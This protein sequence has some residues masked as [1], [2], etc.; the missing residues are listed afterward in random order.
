ML[1][2][3]PKHLLGNI[4]SSPSR[5]TFDAANSSVDLYLVTSPIHGSPWTSRCSASSK[6]AMERYW[7]RHSSS[8]KQAGADSSVLDFCELNR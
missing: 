2:F 6:I 8:W 4:M 7:K 3:T 1:S 5:T